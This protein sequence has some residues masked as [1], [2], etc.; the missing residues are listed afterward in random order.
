[1]GPGPSAN[2][3]KA[4]ALHVLGS[5]SRKREI[6]RSSRPLT[7]RE[8]TGAGQTPMPQLYKPLTPGERAQI[9]MQPDDFWLTQRRRSW[10]LTMAERF[11][12][13]PNDGRSSI[14]SRAALAKHLMPELFPAKMD[15]PGRYL[16]DM[17]QVAIARRRLGKTVKV[18]VVVSSGKMT[19]D[20]E[21]RNKDIA[22]AHVKALGL[23]LYNSGRPSRKR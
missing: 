21:A 2:W 15:K 23:K 5:R 6:V 16:N 17:A 12:L 7:P 9:K 11:R 13:L 18:R 19:L 10:A 20:V 8:L 1:M 22:Q 14:R 4:G 3:R